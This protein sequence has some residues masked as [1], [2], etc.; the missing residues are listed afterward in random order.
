MYC[1]LDT[2]TTDLHPGQIGQLSYICLDDHFQFLQAKNHFFMVERMSP[3][4]EAVH[5]FSQNKLEYLSGGKSFADCI[6]EIA[7]DLSD[8]TL[9]I[10]N[11]PFDVRFLTAEYE[12]AR[13]DVNRKNEHCTMRYFTNICQVPKHSG[14]WYK[15]P[16]VA[17]LMNFFAISD[18]DILHKA[19]E[20]FASD[21]I[22]FHDARFDTAA[23]LC[24]L[25]RHGRDNFLK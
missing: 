9:V 21:E 14:L 25:E 19:Q 24:A 7:S 15:R 13:H 4:A 12:T 18:R 5:G 17:E 20:V 8:Q 6:D 2:E 1:I 3:G 16:K 22:W 11:S 10:H 23:L